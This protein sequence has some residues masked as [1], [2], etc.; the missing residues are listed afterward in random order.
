[1]PVTISMGGPG[2]GAHLRPG[3]RVLGTRR[4]GGIT[5]ETKPAWN[6][7]CLINR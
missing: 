5:G 6:G 4:L 2:I 1:M 7:G 3:T